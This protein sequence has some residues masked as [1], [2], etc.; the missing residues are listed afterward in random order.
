MFTTLPFDNISWLIAIVFTLGSVVWI[1][2]SFF[3]F[4]PMEHGAPP[5]LSAYGC[6][7]TAFIGSSI[8]ALGSILLMLE[9]V[10]DNRDVSFGWTVNQQWDEDTGTTIYRVLPENKSGAHQQKR[11]L[12]SWTPSIS[13]PTMRELRKHYIHE[14]VFWSSLIQVLSS[15]TFLV[16]GITSLPRI[17]DSLSPPLVDVFY[18]TPK[19]VACCGFITSAL[20]AMVECQQKW[21]KPAWRS[22]GWRICLWK[23]LGSFAFL[24]VPC[25]GYNRADWAQYVATVHCLWGESCPYLA[26]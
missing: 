24:L 25:F 22:L 14:L 15:F 18:W 6:G 17:Y 12:Q 5:S 10:K 23:A 21:H 26:L 19:L 2:S 11:E 20:L 16:S 13:L 8:F 3:A 9:S 4:M 1:L 7:I